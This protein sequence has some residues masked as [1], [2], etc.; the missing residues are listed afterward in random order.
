MILLLLHCETNCKKKFSGELIA[1]TQ[2]SKPDYVSLKVWRAIKYF[3]L[4][5]EIICY[6]THISNF[7]VK[8]HPTDCCEDVF[9]SFRVLVNS[10]NNFSKQNILE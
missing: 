8:T 10:L 2:V 1:S 4:Y 5:T 6:N 3:L 9:G 7:I